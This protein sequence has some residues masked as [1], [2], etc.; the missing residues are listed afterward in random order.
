MA[1]AMCSFAGCI[2]RRRSELTSDSKAILPYLMCQE[3]ADHHR[4]GSSKDILKHL[5]VV[6]GEQFPEA[7]RGA[8]D[9]IGTV[10][11]FTGFA[12]MG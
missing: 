8:S 4:K 12:G 6:P 3:H 1:F 5:S 2:F 9:R 10:F 7:H 11:T